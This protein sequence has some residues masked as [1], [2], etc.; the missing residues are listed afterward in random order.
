MVDTLTN[1]YLPK[2]QTES[3]SGMFESRQRRSIIIKKA[4]LGK[5]NKTVGEVTICFLFCKT[6][7]H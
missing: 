6:N 5:V 1:S 7:N 4:P 3:C 2:Q